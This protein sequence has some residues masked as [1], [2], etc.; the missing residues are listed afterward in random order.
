MF[1]YQPMLA[2][3]KPQKCPVCNEASVSEAKAI[4][5]LQYKHSW[6]CLCCGQTFFKKENAPAHNSDILYIYASLNISMW[7]EVRY[8]LRMAY[9][10]RTKERHIV[11]GKGFNS[12]QVDIP[13]SYLE[14]TF[15]PS[16]I[17]DNMLYKNHYHICDAGNYEVYITKGEM[18]NHF[19]TYPSYED[20]LSMREL[21]EFFD[22]N[23]WEEV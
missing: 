6:E 20:S 4:D 15:S 13:D 22:S 23:Q 17:T 21:I 14:K 18:S 16:R 1:L 10:T 11:L 2:N 7:F 12:K 5:G 19:V 3:G 8:K 9:N